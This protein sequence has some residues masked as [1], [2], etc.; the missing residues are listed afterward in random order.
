MA[1]ALQSL[2][3]QAGKGK[4]TKG[5]KA[6]NSTPANDRLTHREGQQPAVSK[7]PTTSTPKPTVSDSDATM[8]TLP[9]PTPGSAPVNLLKQAFMPVNATSSGSGNQG[10]AGSSSGVAAAVAAT[11]APDAEP[12][13]LGSYHDSEE[14]DFD[15]RM[16]AADES[17]MEADTQ[18]E[19]NMASFTRAENEEADKADDGD[20]NYDILDETDI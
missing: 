8:D 4:K 1:A 13:S 6:K 19:E 7:K 5:Q 9:P 3:D 10:T 17:L 18:L 16:R 15:E 14:D 20:G 12:E 2:A 11:I